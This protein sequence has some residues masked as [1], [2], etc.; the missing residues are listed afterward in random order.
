[1]TTLA[2]LTLLA[3][4]QAAAEKTDPEWDRKFE[5]F[6]KIELKDAA[7]HV[8]K[9]VVVEFEVKAGNMLEAKKTCFLNSMADHRDDDNF[10][11]VI[12][13]DGLKSFA[14]KKV[15]DPAAHF[16]GKK[17]RVA[18]QVGLHQGKPQIKV[19]DAGQ[20]RLAEKDKEKK[21]AA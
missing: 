17:V 12:F 1:M 15:D 4:G 2:L 10:T 20:I 8:G 11:V 6:P 3:F 13:R 16:K 5:K 7:D 18:G 19:S 14:E 9:D 21:K